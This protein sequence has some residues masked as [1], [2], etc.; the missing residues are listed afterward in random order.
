VVVAAVRVLIVG[1]CDRAALPRL[2]WW[3]R[4][5]DC[6]GWHGG[7]AGVTVVARSKRWRGVNCQPRKSFSIHLCAYLDCG[8]GC[9]GAVAAR[10][11]GKVAVAWRGVVGVVSG[12]VWVAYQ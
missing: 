2:A 10:C 11:S 3:R 5:C 4:G 6:G 9:V 1:K 7:G 12:R 8:G